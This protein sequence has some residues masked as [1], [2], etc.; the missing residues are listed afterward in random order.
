[1]KYFAHESVSDVEIKKKKEE[2]EIR[3]ENRVNGYSDKSIR[4]KRERERKRNK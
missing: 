2:K 3:K 4:M 1:M